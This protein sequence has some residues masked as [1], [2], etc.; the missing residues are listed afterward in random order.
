MQAA[1]KLATY[2]DLLALPERVRAEVIHGSIVVQPA[3]LPEHGRAQGSIWR[4]I[5]GP[6]DDDDGRGGPGGWWILLEV[7]VRL[8]AHDILRP[9]VAGW[10]RDRLPRPWGLRPIDVVPDWVC[11]ILSPSS[12]SHDRVQ[13]AALYASAG[14]PFF[15]IVDPVGRVV[16]A[17][18]LEHHSEQGRWVRLGAWDSGASA[19]IPP[20][21]QVQLEVARI[22]P[23]EG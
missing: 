1:A 4:S 12:Q 14:V 23:P 21:E 6:F 15:W 9:D 5:G 7:D 2:E 16:E 20:F 3:P 22:F 10:R 19:S 11:E 17:F 8:G 13:K 18:Q